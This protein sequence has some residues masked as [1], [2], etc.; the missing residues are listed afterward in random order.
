MFQNILESLR[1][2]TDDVRLRMQEAE[3][4]MHHAVQ[5]E[6]TDRDLASK[7]RK[8][9]QESRERL[10]AIKAEKLRNDL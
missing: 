1:Q 5:L 6:E 2:Y 3:K 9:I 10:R 4:R 8:L 7:S